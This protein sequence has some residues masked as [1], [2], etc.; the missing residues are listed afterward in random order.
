MKHK[1]RFRRRIFAKE[2]RK[3]VQKYM[4]RINDKLFAF[5][6]MLIAGYFVLI[7]IPNISI[8]SWWFVLPVINMLLSILIELRFLNYSSYRVKMIEE[9]VGNEN[10]TYM[11]TRLI[12]WLLFISRV[13]TIVTAIIFVYQVIS[14]NK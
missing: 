12:T 4:D 1:D 8:N 7:A 14:I 6:T 9:K 3:N 10:I 2:L 13:L 5:N 11:K